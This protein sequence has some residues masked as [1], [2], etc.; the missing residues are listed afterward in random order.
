MSRLLLSRRRVIGAGTVGVA[1]LMLEGCDRLSHAPR[2]QDAIGKAT[3]LTQAS[4]RLLLSGQ[5]LAKEFSAA[6]LSPVFRANGSVM[7]SG[8]AYQ[9]LLEGGFADWRLAVEG[10]V[11]HPILLSLNQLKAMPARTQITRHDCVEGWS[12]IGGWTGVQ[13]ARVLALAGPRP[14]ARYVVF[15]C[16]D[17]LGETGDA[18]GLYYES[19]DFFDAYHPQTILAYAMNGQPLSVAHGAPLRLRVERQLGYKQAKYVMRIQLVD[20][21]DRIGGGKGGFWE[22][23]G[24]AWYAGI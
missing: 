11:Q 22:D 17:D 3:D 1:G 19:I 23:R 7:P 15:R 14:E 18:R 20:R 10:L 8:E 9:G 4:Q 12:A 16:A 5:P 2:F 24:Y 6:Q 21:L 13:L